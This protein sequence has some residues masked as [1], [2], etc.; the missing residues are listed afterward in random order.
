MQLK[1]AFHIDNP[2]DPQQELSIIH[3]IPILVN[4]FFG[5]QF[6]NGKLK[7]ENTVIIKMSAH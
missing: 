1:A 5:E 6:C 2:A 3:T 7:N 4:Y